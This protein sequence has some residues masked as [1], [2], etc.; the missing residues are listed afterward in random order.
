METITRYGTD[1]GYFD[2]GPESDLFPGSQ[3]FVDKYPFPQLQIVWG[4]VAVE[5]D[6]H[7][8]RIIT[9]FCT[10]LYFAFPCAQTCSQFVFLPF[11][12]VMD[13][14]WQIPRF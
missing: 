5:K 11:D 6:I 8:T 1:P 7:L 3:Q 9:R 4:L 12:Y 14:L 13:A 10:D 2:P